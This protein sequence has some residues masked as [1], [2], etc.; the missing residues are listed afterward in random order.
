[1]FEG[2]IMKE[3]DVDI[4]GIGYL[5]DED[6][7]YTTLRVS[8][9]PEDRRQRI[10]KRQKEEDFFLLN[11]RDCKVFEAGNE[12]YLTDY[13]QPEE[14]E[15]YSSLI[16]LAKR[17]IVPERIDPTLIEREIDM[18]MIEQDASFAVEYAGFTI[19]EIK[20]HYNIIDETLDRI[21]EQKEES[22]IHKTIPREI[23]RGVAK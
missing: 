13:F 18:C 7:Y 21:T 16:E 15:G 8:N 22:I 10:L 23:A 12:L 17:S 14:F 11:S 2:V 3:K 1:M 20:K 19:E 6:K 5:E 4:V 9:I